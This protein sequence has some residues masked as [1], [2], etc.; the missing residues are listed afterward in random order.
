MRSS[1]EAVYLAL[2]GRLAR[3]QWNTSGC[4]SSSIAERQPDPLYLNIAES[5]RCA[6]GDGGDDEDVQYSCPASFVLVDARQ[7]SFVADR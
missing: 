4:I 1:V 3:A 2:S 5:I 6:L 7:Q